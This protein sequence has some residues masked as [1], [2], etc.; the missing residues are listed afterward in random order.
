MTEDRKSLA[1]E[2][3]VLSLLAE[4]GYVIREV[5]SLA[6]WQEPETFSGGW[7]D[8][9]IERNQKRRDEVPLYVL[10]HERVIF[11]APGAAERIRKALAK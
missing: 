11:G 7:N 2:P 3:T 8:S 9:A 4:L 5:A 6:P 1:P 10:H